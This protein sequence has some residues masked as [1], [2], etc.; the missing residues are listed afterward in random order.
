MHGCKTKVKCN[1]LQRTLPSTMGEY[2]RDVATRAASRPFCWK[3]EGGLTAAL[4][5]L[6]LMLKLKLMVASSS[7]FASG[8]AVDLLPAKVV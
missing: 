6:T 1:I 5:V 4:M 3:P 7:N 8:L 2:F